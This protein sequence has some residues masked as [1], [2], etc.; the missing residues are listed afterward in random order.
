MMIFTDCGCTKLIYNNTG[1]KSLFG[2]AQ[3][4][5]FL[6]TMQVLQNGK[7]LKFFLNAN[8]TPIFRDTGGRLFIQILQKNAVDKKDE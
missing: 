2:T 4:F 3:S 6:R 5:F 1:Q 8:R 7:T